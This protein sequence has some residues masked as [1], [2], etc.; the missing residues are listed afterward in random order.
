MAR[1]VTTSNLATSNPAENIYNSSEF[2]AW[3]PRPYMNRRKAELRIMKLISAGDVQL[4]EVRLQ[5]NEQIEERVDLGRLSKDDLT[6]SKYMGVIMAAMACRAAIDGGLPEHI[7][8]NLSDAFI[9]EIDSMKDPGQLNE[10]IY[11][12]IIENCRA[13]QNNRLMNLSAPVKQCCEYF[14]VKMHNT[15]TLEE[16]SKVCHL[17]PNYI[18]DLFRKELGMGAI[19]YFQK[20]KLRMAGYFL[21]HTELSVS[22]IAETLA[23]PSHSHF[24]QRFKKQYGCTPSEYR[25]QRCK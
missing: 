3:A 6:H 2:S 8:F 12:V 19:Q 23:Y 11:S 9:R 24:A 10:L 4:L 21:E 22:D 7:A 5:Q 13:V 18:S 1:K 20:E 25:E 16:L 15:V 14:Y 17:S